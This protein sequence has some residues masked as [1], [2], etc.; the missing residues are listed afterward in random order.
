MLDRVALLLIPI[1]PGVVPRARG[2]VLAV[3]GA[4]QR[5]VVR[6]VDRDRWLMG[7]RPDIKCHLLFFIKILQL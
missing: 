1:V 6:Q 4:R 2:D 5:L 3:V 7:R